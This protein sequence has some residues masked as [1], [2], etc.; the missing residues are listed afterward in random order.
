MIVYCEV[1]QVDKVKDFTEIYS[2]G[3]NWGGMM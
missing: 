3:A 2:M 1:E